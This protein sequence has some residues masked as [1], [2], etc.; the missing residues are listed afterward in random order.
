MPLF[1]RVYNILQREIKR[2]LGKTNSDALTR[3]EL[4]K[5]RWHIKKTI[6]NGVKE[7]MS[8][9][10]LIMIQPTPFLP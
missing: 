8:K 5:G 6:L 1:L 2:T 3:Y 7:D 10:E 9:G 4:A